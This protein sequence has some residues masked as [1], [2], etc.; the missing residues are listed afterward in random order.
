MKKDGLWNVKTAP[1][2]SVPGYSA[3]MAATRKC[4]RAGFV[5]RQAHMH[6]CLGVLQFLL[7]SRANLRKYP[8]FFASESQFLPRKLPL[9]AFYQPR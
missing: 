1:G 2:S 6:A 9:L 3:A 4:R 7:K 8:P 5:H